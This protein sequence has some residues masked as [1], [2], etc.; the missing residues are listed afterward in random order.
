M[1][2]FDLDGAVIGED[3][4]ALV[5]REIARTYRVIPVQVSGEQVVL[6]ATG[7][8]FF[9]GVDKDLRFMLNRSVELREAPLDEVLR[10][11]DRFYPDGS[12]GA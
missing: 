6:A 8:N 5:S 11:L 10:A 9:T 2:L 7:D 4:L 1:G 3:I 12:S